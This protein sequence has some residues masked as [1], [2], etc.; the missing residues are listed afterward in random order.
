M[1]V[2][3]GRGSYKRQMTAKG[4]DRLKKIAYIFFFGKIKS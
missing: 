3:D 2:F 4:N 1:F